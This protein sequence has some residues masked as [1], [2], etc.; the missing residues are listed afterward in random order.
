VENVNTSTLQHI[1]T[2]ITK[3]MKIIPAIDLIDGKCVRLSQGDYDTKKVYSENPLE[4]AKKF[5]SIGITNLHLVDLDGAKSR[6]M[7]NHEVLKT[8]SSN[9]NLEIDFGGGIKSD[10]DIE[11]AFVSGAKQV[12]VGTIAVQNKS[13][14]MSWLERYTAKKLILGADVKNGNIAIQGWQSQTKVS[15]WAFLDYYTKQGVEYVICTDISK[16]GMLSGSSMDLYADILKK[17]PQMKLIASGGVSSISEMV[18]LE[19]MGLY[20]AII[21]K[22]IYENQISMNEL[23]EFVS[24]NLFGR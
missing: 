19:K 7:V 21:G 18:E 17:Y 13:L 23:G 8:I 5:E 9:T 11:L 20:G 24:P 4:V 2:S 10:V 15:I 1:N 22:A 16:D 12:T 3:K 6:H 14:F